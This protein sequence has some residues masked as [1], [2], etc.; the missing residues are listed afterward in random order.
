MI[1]KQVSGWTVNFCPN[2]PESPS[3]EF[4]IRKLPPP[5]WKTSDLRWPKFTP[6]IPPPPQWKTSDLRWPKFTLKYPPPNPK[7]KTSDLRW[8]KF[9]PKYPPMKNFRFGMT[10]VYSKIPPPPTKNFRFEMTKVYSEI[11][12]PQ[13][14]NEKLQI[15]D[16][17]SL[18]RNTPQWK[19]SDLRWLKFTPKYPPKM[20]NFRF[21]MTKVY[22]EIPPQ[23]EK[24]QIWDDQSLLRNTPSPPNEKLQIWDDQSLL[25]NTPPPSQKG[26]QSGRLYVET[27]LYPPWIPLVPFCFA[28]SANFGTPQPGSSP[29]HILHPHLIRM[30]QNTLTQIISLI[31]EL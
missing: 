22:S 8:P 29:P 27:N 19:T 3:L 18:L 14:P 20:K 21:E 16:D 23:N 2:S 13:I 6:K 1:H 11:P 15:W 30:S 9:T 7:W 26:L 12:P 24:L 4:Q 28:M 10:K 5:Q 25:R 31:A 17:Q